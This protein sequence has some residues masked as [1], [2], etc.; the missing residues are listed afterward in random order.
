MDILPKFFFSIQINL[1]LYHWQTNSYARHIATD[2]IL[3]KIDPLI[4]TFIEIYQGKFGKIS[5]G[6][7][8]ITLRTLTD[9]E[10]ASDFLSKCIN[11]L[12]NIIE[13]DVNMSTSDT[14]LLN[15]RDEMVGLLN[16]TLY[17]FSFN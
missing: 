17:L 15:I 13:E 8:N 1:K 9:D 16:Q 3:T 10:T 14:D 4:D 6:S 11:Y 5:T 2:S 12:N 7:T